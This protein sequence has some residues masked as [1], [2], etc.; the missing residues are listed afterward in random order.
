MGFRF[1]YS[2]NGAGVHVVNDFIVVAWCVM[3]IYIEIEIDIEMG[4][5]GT[6][7]H[8]RDGSIG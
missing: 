7:G 2:S 6:T 3:I 4:L 1:G 5:F 8:G